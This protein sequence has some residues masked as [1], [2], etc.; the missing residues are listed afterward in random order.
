M[1]GAAARSVSA[2][3][4]RIAEKSDD[5]E[6]RHLLRETPMRGAA[7]VTFEREPDYF[8]GEN[9]ACGEDATIL[10][11]AGGTLACM[12][13][14][15][16]RECWVNGMPMRAGYLAELR[17]AHRMRG[18]SAMLR[19]GY[20]FFA[21]LAAADSARCHFTAI[22]SDNARA[23]RILEA[24]KPGMPRYRF[25]SE[26]VTLLITVP[27]TAIAAGHHRHIAASPEHIPD[28]LRVL[29]AHGRNHQFGSVWTE[30]RLRSLARHGLPLER[31]LLA[32]DG[33]EAVACG[34][35]WDQRAFRQTVIRRLPP[36]L[37][38]LRPF[39]NAAGSF[40]Q[41]PRV[42]APGIPLAHAFLSPLACASE[43]LPD[44]TAAFFP[45]ARAAGCEF[46]TL[47]LAADDPCLPAMRRR[48]ALREW[49]SRIYTVEFPC[50]SAAALPA[51]MPALPEVA[52][53]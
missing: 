16:W 48:F 13:R 10:G 17:V 46:L 50:N 12:G 32:L 21:G 31:F 38:I 18:R 43:S 44:F 7:D 6:I 19:E 36:L 25:V 40:F 30:A 51:G 41:L 33:R 3:E 8:A 34:A 45:M 2:C 35:L 22:L 28:L 11:F 37:R 23:R 42:P 9:I 1:A 4:F 24:G 47:A 52:L 29:N 27:R 14:C 49:R 26:I 53:L 20:R 15:S 39:I 5:A